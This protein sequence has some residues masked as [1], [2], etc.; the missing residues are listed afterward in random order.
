MH[1][2]QNL[3]KVYCQLPQSGS[4][5]K[6]KCD[7]SLFSGVGKVPQHPFAD[8]DLKAFDGNFPNLRFKTTN[9][10]NRQTFC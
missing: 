8:K 7:V 6:R 2:H 1:Q 4:S 9:A 10:V 5:S 3:L